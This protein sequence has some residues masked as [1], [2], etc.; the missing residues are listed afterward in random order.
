[1]DNLLKRS[2]AC[3]AVAAGI[4]GNAALGVYLVAR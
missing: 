2:Y 4:S 1:M 3:P